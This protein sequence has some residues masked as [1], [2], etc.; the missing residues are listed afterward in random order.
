[1]GHNAY[2]KLNWLSI[3]FIFLLFV[4][5]GLV[6]ST[7][8]GMGCPDWPKCFGEYVP[9]TSE[10]E[11]PVNYEDFFTNQRVQKT[12]RFVSLLKKLV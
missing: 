9:P 3:F 4:I 2:L 1:M 12:E 10:S 7:G 8:S 6:R 11:L 5:G